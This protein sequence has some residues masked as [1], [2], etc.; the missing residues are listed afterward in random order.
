MYFLG[1]VIQ[2]SVTEISLSTVTVDKDKI[3]LV[4][5][6]DPVSILFVT[7]MAAVPKTTL[8]FKPVTLEI[9]F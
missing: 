4:S 9:L 7:N 3:I 8:K 6:A 1:E 5:S 2:A